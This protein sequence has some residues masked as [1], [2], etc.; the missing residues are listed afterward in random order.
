MATLISVL[1]PFAAG[2][3][4]LI[5]YK[6]DED[7]IT[8][9]NL[10]NVTDYGDYLRPAKIISTG[11]NFIIEFKIADLISWIRDDYTEYLKNQCV[12][13]TPFDY[14]TI[15]SKLNIFRLDVSDDMK[16]I[17]PVKISLDERVSDD[18]TYVQIKRNGK[19]RRVP[20]NELKLLLSRLNFKKNS[21]SEKNE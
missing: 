17:I 3:K 9:Y 2:F 11:D 12:N 4:T 16:N 13:I 10:C 5:E 1:G 6:E 19:V 14:V 18:H 15:M 8:I 7:K 21:E 20:D